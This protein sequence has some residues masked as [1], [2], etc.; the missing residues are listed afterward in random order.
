M[1]SWAVEES[2]N[3]RMVC[4]SSTVK[5]PISETAMYRYC[6]ATQ[7]SFFGLLHLR[8][9]SLF[10]L[11]CLVIA[12]VDVLEE[13]TIVPRELRRHTLPHLPRWWAHYSPVLQW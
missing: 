11:V 2:L 5:I 7:T 10:E 13:L 1:N 3:K 8:R 9:S 12:W 6:K 4:K